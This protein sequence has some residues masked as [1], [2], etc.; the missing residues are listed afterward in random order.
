MTLMIIFI[1]GLH[2]NG[3]NFP[4]L[5]S[6]WVKSIKPIKKVCLPL[7]F[8][9]LFF[10]SH[11]HW[12]PFYPPTTRDFSELPPRYWCRGFENPLW[13]SRVNLVF[14]ETGGL[15]RNSSAVSSPQ[16]GLY[17]EEMRLESA[18]LSS[19]LSAPVLME[20]L[21]LSV[22]LYLLSCGCSRRAPS[23]SGCGSPSR[24]WISVWRGII[25]VYTQRKPLR[26]W[27]L[28]WASSCSCREEVGWVPKSYSF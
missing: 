9:P 24:C 14:A 7:R 20:M 27:P 22:Y 23:K 16:L 25:L 15:Q 21:Y 13:Q 28:N 18:L 5:F 1:A 2:L 10:L 6:L 11:Q 17:C 4:L 3:I 8:L 12:C 26:C 19:S